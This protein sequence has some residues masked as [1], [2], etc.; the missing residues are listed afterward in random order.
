MDKIGLK[1][2]TRGRVLSSEKN[3]HMREH[4]HQNKIKKKKNSLTDPVKRLQMK[5]LESRVSRSVYFFIPPGVL[6]LR[7]QCY[8]TAL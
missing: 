2:T 1:T 7:Q 6:R 4:C 5:F 8:G 3:E